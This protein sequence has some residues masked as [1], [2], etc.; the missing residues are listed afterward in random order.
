LPAELA[1]F[2]QFTLGKSVLMGRRTFH[3]IGRPLPHRRNLILSQQTNFQWPG[4]EIYHSLESVVSA[5]DSKEE[6]MVIGGAMIYQQMLPFAHRL[7]LTFIDC[8]P[9]GDAYFPPWNPSDW[10]EV[11]NTFHP[12]DIHNHYSFRTVQFERTAKR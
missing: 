12:A 5:W 11:T 2:K 6:L 4:C 8:D 1:H 3:S 10:R 9:P 7:Y